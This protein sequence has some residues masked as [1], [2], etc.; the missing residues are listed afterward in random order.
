MPV[1]Y[2][3]TMRRRHPLP[4][5]RLATAALVGLVAL[6]CG[7]PAPSPTLG[8][9]TTPPSA[10]APSTG[11]SVPRERRE[12][13][14]VAAVTRLGFRGRRRPARPGN[15]RVATEVVVD[16][17]ASPLWVGPV[18]DGS[19]RLSVAEQDGRIRL[20]DHG[21]LAPDAWLDITI[22]VLAGGE[23]GLLGV[24]F[25]PGFGRRAPVGLRPLLGPRRRHEGRRGRCPAR[26]RDPRPIDAARAPRRAAALR[27]TT[28][29]AGSASTRRGCCSSRSATVAAAATPRT[30]RRASTRS[31]ARS[32]ASTSSARRPARRTPSRPTTP[33]RARRRTPGDPPPRPAQ[34]VPRQHR[35]ATGDL[36]IGDVGQNAWEEVDVA[37][38][39]A[40]A[41]TSAGGGGRA[42]HCYD[43]PTGCDPTGVTMPV[44]EYPHAAGCAVI[45]G[46]VYHGDAVPAA[47][48]RLPVLRQLLGH[49]VGDRRRPRRRPGADH[50]ARDGP[51][52]QLDRC[53]RR[54]RGLSHRPRRRRA[55][56]AGAPP[57]DAP[58]S[59]A[60]GADARRT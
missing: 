13:V 19:G 14:A 44:T 55:A 26:R 7:G 39:G 43:P 22:A 27:R 41:S 9:P 47:P 21:A 46:V 49:A 28:T 1:P 12:P 10:A 16:G 54:G 34:P 32:C 40:G 59:G 35:P 56:A 23:R 8:S 18:P 51:R 6:A 48:G 31:S 38:A 5:T 36:W 11:L 52:D 4:R 17:L 33:S 45:G 57:P 20:V 42:R 24:A 3:G 60:R 53:R 58:S 25:P 15:V 29:A 50:P 30:G 37:P 2:A